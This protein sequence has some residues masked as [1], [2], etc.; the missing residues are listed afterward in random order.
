MRKVTF[1]LSMAGQQNSLG[2][3]P[4]FYHDVVKEDMTLVLVYDHN[5]PA[6]MVWFPPVIEDPQTHEPIPIALLVEGNESEPQM[7]YLAYPTGVRFMYR[8]EEFCLLTVEKEI[9]R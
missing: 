5:H 2:Q 4:C 8:N 3:F 9:A 7:L 1:E 6:Q